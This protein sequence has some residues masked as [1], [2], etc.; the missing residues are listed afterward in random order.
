MKL[1]KH[2]QN[3][4]LVLKRFLMQ[5]LRQIPAPQA[6]DDKPLK[7][8][9]FDSWF[10]EYRGVI[11]LIAIHDGIIKKGDKITSCTSRQLL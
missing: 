5:S 1:L 10:D 7:A 11:C 4:E 3:Q 6:S 9:L 8:L 2:L